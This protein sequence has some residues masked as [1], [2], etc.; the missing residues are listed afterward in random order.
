MLNTVCALGVYGGVRMWSPKKGS[1]SNRI[2]TVSI[3]AAL[4]DMC[5]CVIYNTDKREKRIRRINQLIK[6]YEA[7]GHVFSDNLLDFVEI[8]SAQPIAKETAA[9]TSAELLTSLR[10]ELANDANSVDGIVY[11]DISDNWSPPV[12][13]AFHGSCTKFINQDGDVYDIMSQVAIIAFCALLQD[14]A[15]FANDDCGAELLSGAQLIFKGGAAIGKFL[16]QKHPIWD[17]LT[18]AEK[19]D[20][21]TSFISGGDNDTS[22]Y[23]AN[24]KTVAKKHQPEQISQAIRQMSSRLNEIL[25]QVCEEFQ[26]VKLLS[27]HSTQMV[28]SQ[29]EFAECAFDMS[30]RKT[31]GFQLTNVDAHC[32]DG[33]D[34]IDERMALIPYKERKS[35]HVFTTQSKVEFQ[36]GTDKLAKFELIRAKLAF[37]AKCDDMSVGTYSELLDISIGYPESSSLFPKQWTSVQF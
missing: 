15:L 18:D 28:Q 13:K 37:M 7:Y 5:Q 2:G 24:M 26:V 23:F 33:F 12:Q 4:Y 14:D 35:S 20:I 17:Q 29:I 10:T 11:F 30:I 27:K 3:E 9:A 8:A 31:K 21:F 1:F 36:I 22:I 34:V 16:F 25:F 6:Y 32:E 19:T